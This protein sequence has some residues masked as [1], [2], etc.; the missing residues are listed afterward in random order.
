MTVVI[1]IL[2]GVAA[3]ILGV[4]LG[5]GGGV[6]LV[7]ALVL[8]TGMTVKQAIPCSMAAVLVNSIKA[9]EGHLSRENVKFQIGGLVEFIFIVFALVGTHLSL[10]LSVVVLTKVFALTTFLIAAVM[11]QDLWKSRSIRNYESN[12]S[13]GVSD[14]KKKGVFS[15]ADSLLH[16]MGVA[17]SKRPAPIALISSFS[18]L[19]AGLLGLGGGIIQVPSLNLLGR[20]SM[21]KAAGTASYAMGAA[22]GASA[23]TFFIAGEVDLHALAWVVVGI[24]V[25][26]ILAIK[27][28]H[29]VSQSKLKLFF[30]AMLIISGA[31][32]W[33]K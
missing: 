17:D 4:S 21:Q 29:S 6:V 25:G 16:D 27:F 30:I 11:G 14:K 20:L 32:M 28:L 8:A 26:G 23:L 5:L 13:K 18:G 1:L 19:A 31:K 15:K 12:Y 24:N 9:T 33:M 2:A 3:G 7:P 10:V 22:A